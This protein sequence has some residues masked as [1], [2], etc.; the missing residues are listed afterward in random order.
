MDS[1]W[2]FLHPVWSELWGHR[3]EAGAG[4]EETGASAAAGQEEKPLSEG[5]A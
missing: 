3:S 5:M 1:R 2:R 4:N